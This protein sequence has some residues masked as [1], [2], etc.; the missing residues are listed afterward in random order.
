MKHMKRIVEILLYL[1]QLPQNLVG[2]LLVLVLRPEVKYNYDGVAICYAS[3]MRGGIS[4]GKY[5]I[6][7]DVFKDHRMGDERHELGHSIQSRYLG[8][9]YLFVI[10]LPSILWAAWWNADR[11]RDYYSFYTERWADRLGGV[12]RC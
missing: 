10:G 7:R 1:W 11:N 12:N 9:L 5:V 8:P 4:L 2:L 3:R 6:M